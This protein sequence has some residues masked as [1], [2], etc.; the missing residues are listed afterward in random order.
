MGSQT[1]TRRLVLL[2]AVTWPRPM[3]AQDV[4]GTWT[5]TWAQAV[6]NNRDGT[7]E[8][9]KWGDAVLVLAQDGDHVSGE[10]T[11]TVLG[12]VTWKVE[13]SVQNGRLILS[14]SEHDS[15]DPQLAQ[16][17]EMRWR[18]TLDGDR[19]EGEMTLVF[20]GAERPRAWRPWRAARA[21][22]GQEFPGG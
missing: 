21:R 8:I 3:A 22:G 19:L 4:A 13:G 7:Q 11:T 5:V 2:L 18:G 9:Q 1:W 16:V 6:R 14:A 20:R 12:R 15:N 10:W 17:G